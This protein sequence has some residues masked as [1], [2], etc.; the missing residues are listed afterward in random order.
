MVASASFAGALIPVPGV[1]ITADLALLTREVNL[2]KSQ[3]GLPEENSSQFQRMSKE[4]QARFRKFCVSGLMEIAN[5]L[6]LYAASSTVEEASRFIPIIG[7]VI[8]GSISFA[9]TYH[10]LQQCLNELE[11]AALDYLDDV[12]EDA[13]DELYID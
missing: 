5:L 7:T 4:N 2:Y 9:T 12:R 1:S 13:Y 11:K 6:A 8:A 10:F 3:L